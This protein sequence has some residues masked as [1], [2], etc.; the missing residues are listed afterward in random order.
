MG[1][2]LHEMAVFNK[3]VAS[4]SLTAAARDLGISTAAVSRKLAALE[5]RLGVRLA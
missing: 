3:V 1:D 5:G 4:G 2:P